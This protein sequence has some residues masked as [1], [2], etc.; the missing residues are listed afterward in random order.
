MIVQA[1]AGP[2]AVRPDPSRAEAAF[3]S[4]RL[5]GAAS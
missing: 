2:L 4:I 1:E 3:D 5:P